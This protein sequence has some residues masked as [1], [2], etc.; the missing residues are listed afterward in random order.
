MKSDN[1]KKRHPESEREGEYPDVDTRVSRG[2][3][4]ESYYTAEDKEHWYQFHPGGPY[5]EIDKDGNKVSITSGHRWSTTTEGKTTTIEGIKDNLTGKGTRVTDWA[6]HHNETGGDNTFGVHGQ[7]LR[8]VKGGMFRYSTGATEHCSEGGHFNDHNDGDQHDHSKG[9]RV[10][11][12][13]GNYYGTSGGEWGQYAQ[14]NIDVKTDKKGRFYSEKAMLLQAND[15]WSAASSKA[16]SLSTQDTWSA[17]SQK[18][19]S[20]SSEQKITINGKQEVT[21]TSDTKI[22]LKVGSNKIEITSSGI[23]IDAGS[24]KLDLKASGDVTTQGSTTKLQGGG[25]PGI[26]TTIT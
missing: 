6:D 1:K 17:S 23:T 18:D 7:Y 13:G 2:G 21:I 16:M 11:S 14:G 19:M 22:V 26:P 9:D 25:S 20:S 4:E 12:A 10:W 8:A 3:H 15:T 5:T 24:G